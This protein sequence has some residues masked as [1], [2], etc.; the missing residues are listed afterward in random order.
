[1]QDHN[2]STRIRSKQER[3]HHENLFL[4]EREKNFAVFHESLSDA[5]LVFN[6]AFK[7]SCDFLLRPLCDGKVVVGCF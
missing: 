5:T 2:S 3:I 7:W 4:R 1:M 6:G